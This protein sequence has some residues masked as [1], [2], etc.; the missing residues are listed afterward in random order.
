MKSPDENP[1]SGIDDD[2]IRETAFARLHLG[3][4]EVLKRRRAVRVVVGDDEID[5]TTVAARRDACLEELALDRRLAPDVAKGVVPLVRDASGVLRIGDPGDAIDWALRLARLPDADRAADR[6]E[7]GRLSE[8]ALEAIARHVARFH[9]RAR[10]VSIEPS[11]VET[12]LH[13]W[14]RLRIDSPEARHREPLPEEA[15]RAEAWQR[16]FLER[17]SDRLVRRAERGTIRAGHGALTLDHVFV[18]DGGRVAIL[19]GLEI[20]PR[21]RDVDVAADVALFATDLAHR[22]RADLAERFVAEYARLANDFDLYPLLDF[23]ASLRAS[24]RA[25]LDWL[26]ADLAVAGSAGERRYRERA[27]RFLALALAQPRRPILPP[28]VVA[29]GGQVASGKSTVARHVA[30]RIGAPVVGSDPTRDYLLGARLNEEL[31]EVRWERSYAPGFGERVYGE[32]LRRAAR[33]LETGR[34]VVVDGCF[35]SRDQRA[36]ARALAERFGLPFLFVEARVSREVQQA[37]LGER[38]LRDGVAIDDWVEIADEMRA[39]W[40][41]AE[42]LP[43]REHLALDTSR[44]LEHNAAAIEARLPTW[45]AGFTG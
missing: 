40:E 27:R 41:S 13:G 20:G 14:I 43:S 32:V 8:E 15:T 18:D 37:R 29:M 39:Q 42:D 12:R 16:S 17:A 44:P 22:G 21:A 24:I 2:E 4:R 45:P 11:S 1:V 25:K 34:P 23:H 26:A 28:V 30:R 35:R 3:E 38:A 7:A 31:H 36:R 10:G 9:E 19:A 6:L 5:L 33:V